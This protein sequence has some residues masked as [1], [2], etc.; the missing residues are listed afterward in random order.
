MKFNNINKF[1]IKASLSSFLFFLFRLSHLSRYNKA[2]D[3]IYVKAYV[4]SDKTCDNIY[5]KYYYYNKGKF[6]NINKFNIKDIIIF[7]LIKLLPFFIS[8]KRNNSR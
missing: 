4:K 8:L 6:S 1:N 7:F 3:K 2:C 5:D